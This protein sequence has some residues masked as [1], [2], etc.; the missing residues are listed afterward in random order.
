VIAKSFRQANGQLFVITSPAR[1][2]ARLTLRDHQSTWPATAPGRACRAWSCVPCL[3][4]PSPSRVPCLVV[5]SPSCVP[6]LAVRAV[7]PGHACRGAWP[8]VPCLPSHQPHLA[9]QAVADRQM[10]HGS[11]S[12]KTRTHRPR[13]PTS[14]PRKI[15]NPRDTKQASVL[16]MYEFSAHTKKGNHSCPT[17]KLSRNQRSR[18]PARPSRRMTRPRN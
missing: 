17:L 1:P 13:P 8:Y 12:S 16:V 3:V 2:G 11:D 9:A 7:A 10:N 5:P 4:V 15:R 6:C 14:Q 18:Q